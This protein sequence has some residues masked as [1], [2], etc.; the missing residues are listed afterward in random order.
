MSGRRR[1]LVR[2]QGNQPPRAVG[3]KD[4]ASLF[5]FE[6]RTKKLLP[7]GMRARSGNYHQVI[8]SKAQKFFASFSKNKPIVPVLRISIAG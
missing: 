5:Y 8:M 1:Y 6:K 3:A 4:E 2:R 7:V